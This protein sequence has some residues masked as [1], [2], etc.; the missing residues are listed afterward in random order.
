MITRRCVLALL[1][2][3]V[4]L[5][6]LGIS[7][8]EAFPRRVFVAPSAGMYYY[9]LDPY[10]S[11]YYNPYVLP[12]PYYGILPP[13]LAAQNM[14]YRYDAGYGVQRTA[15]DYIDASARK[16]PSIY[17]AVPFEKSPAEK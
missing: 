8:A 15:S 4:V 16:R 2:A 6:S 11:Y 14:L 17:P 5:A 1:A 9:P 12:L 13:P 3:A 7:Q 10:Y